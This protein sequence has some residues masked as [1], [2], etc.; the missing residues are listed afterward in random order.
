LLAGSKHDGFVITVE[1]ALSGKLMA[2]EPYEAGVS[3]TY[4]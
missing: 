3:R 2:E 4:L 1:I